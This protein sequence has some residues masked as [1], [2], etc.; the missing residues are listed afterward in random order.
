MNITDLAIPEG[1]A[2]TIDT[3]KQR[4]EIR[5]C[6]ESKDKIIAY[7]P[8]EGLQVYTYLIDG[9]RIP[10]MRKPVLQSEDAGDR[11]HL[12]ICKYG[13]GVLNEKGAK[14]ELRCGEFC[15]RCSHEEENSFSFSAD[16]L[17]GVELVLE[18]QCIE[19][20]SILFRA[21]PHN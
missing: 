3:T 8:V 12:L 17:V 11:L 2:A 15:I 6:G 7:F 13:C 20:D 21:T 1:A 9:G 14:M 5:I 19:K 4:A 16:S 10:D 18:L